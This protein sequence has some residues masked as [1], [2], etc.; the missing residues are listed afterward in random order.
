MDEMDREQSHQDMGHQDMGHQGK[1]RY[2]KARRVAAV[3]VISV[4]SV[5][6]FLQA[7]VYAV[8]LTQGEH[9]GGPVS[10]GQIVLNALPICLLALATTLPLGFLRPLA[11]AVTVALASVVLLVLHWATIAGDVAVVLAAYRLG[12][13]GAGRRRQFVAIAL[14]VPFLVMALAS[15]DFS[16]TLLASCVPAAAGTGFA[17][18]AG[19]SETGEDEARAVLSHTLTEHLARGERA[20]I[21]RELHDVVAHH[22]SMIA[23]RAETARLTTPGMPE[24]GAERLREI[25]DTARAGLTEMRRLLGVLREDVTA[26]EV[27]ERQP[28]PGLPQ[29]ATLVDE[30]REAAPG[31]SVRLI[32]SGPVASFDPGVELVAYRIVQEALTNARRHAPG[33]AVDVEL[34][35]DED[36]LRLR[37]RDNGPGPSDVMP[38]LSH[39]LLGMRERAATVGGTVHT[40]AAP[41]GG[42]LVEAVLP[43]KPDGLT[44]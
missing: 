11:A 24:A 32:V 29:V 15:R 42:F 8:E 3:V 35:Y 22:I 17:I 13:V 7:F 36:T 38:A 39:G 31:G 27:G 1:R 33:A 18:R 10:F 21:A 34:R 19:R 14:A 30:A 43:V 37:I 40:G 44:G 20:R 28:Q 25:G 41:G 4:L 26:Q 6:A 5:G 23:V 16:A 9:D 2:D 12:A